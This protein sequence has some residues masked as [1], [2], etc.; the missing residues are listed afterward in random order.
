MVLSISHAFATSEAAEIEFDFSANHVRPPIEKRIELDLRQPGGFAQLR[1]MSQF[2]PDLSNTE[3]HA[4]LNSLDI[5]V[6]PR[7]IGKTEAVLL[8]GGAVALRGPDATLVCDPVETVIFNQAEVKHLRRVLRVRQDVTTLMHNPNCVTP[9]Q[10]VPRNLPPQAVTIVQNASRLPVRVSFNGPA[11]IQWGLHG[12]VARPLVAAPPLLALAISI[13][14]S[15][16]MNK[17]FGL[18]HRGTAIE[19]DTWQAFDAADRWRLIATALMEHVDELVS[20]TIGDEFRRAFIGA[21]VNGPESIATRIAKALAVLPA[22]FVTDPASRAGAPPP[23][24]RHAMAHIDGLAYPRALLGLDQLA[25]PMAT[26][27]ILRE[28]M[29]Y[30]E[31]MALG[32]DDQ[33]LPGGPAALHSDTALFL[34]RQAGPNGRL[35]VAVPTPISP[36][37]LYLMA[38]EVSRS[39]GGRVIA[40]APC[41]GF[42]HRIGSDGTETGNAGWFGMGAGLDEVDLILGDIAFDQ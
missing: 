20:E 13:V 38:D 19:D 6:P 24:W 9:R 17:G 26:L 2:W 41:W 36:V 32:D 4:W 21:C 3:R 27:R 33:V 16:R 11:V 42:C 22:C 15:P 7:A 5:V 1:K 14:A 29:E 23:V 37:D 31:V 12:A 8:P 30:A 25:D 28:T 40:V 34:A 39:T 10:R 35:A 18:V